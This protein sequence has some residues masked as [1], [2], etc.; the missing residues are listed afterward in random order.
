MVIK[1]K[2]ICVNQKCDRSYK[3]ENK[4]LDTLI[5]IFE[6]LVGF[7]L[8]GVVLAIPIC[9]LLYFIISLVQY[10]VKKIKPDSDWIRKCENIKKAK[11]NLII[12]SC[13]LALFILGIVMPIFWLVILLAIPVFALVY[14]VLSLKEYRKQE[15]NQD[16]SRIDREDNIKK[17][18]RN[19][20]LS[21]MILGF[22]VLIIVSLIYAFSQELFY[23]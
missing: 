10:L 4:E 1:E 19:L 3:G 18:K 6:M 21:S 13:I 5:W 11:T 2:V 12:S 16:N 14:F 20:R 7:L 15:A 8:I 17:A 23:M 9:I 22:I